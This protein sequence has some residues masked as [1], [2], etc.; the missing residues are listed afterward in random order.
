M[1]TLRL[2]GLMVLPLWY[3][4]HLYCLCFIL[5]LKLQ[6]PFGFQVQPQELHGVIDRDKYEDTDEC[7]N[8]G[9]EHEVEGDALVV[10]VPEFKVRCIN[11]FRDPHI[12]VF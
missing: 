9:I 11:Y 3:V 1:A 7:A 12:F 4:R 8:T 6:F 10:K 5:F 2:H